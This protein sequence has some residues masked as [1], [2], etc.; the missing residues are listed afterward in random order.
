MIKTKL[1]TSVYKKPEDLRMA[2]VVVSKRINTRIFGDKGNP[3]PGTV[4]DDVVTLP[5]RYDFFVVSQCVRQGTVSPT[6]Y[7]VLYDNMG[8][9]PDRMQ[10]MAYK[11]CHMY[12]NWSGTVRVPAPCQYAHK[13]AF[14]T[15]QS[16][17]RPA[18]RTLEN[19]L[20]Y[21]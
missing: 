10:I 5:E 4:V 11:L 9:P 19:V 17:H 16:L 15:A 6:S 3:P 1:T 12:Y 14:L 8:L 2:F 21:L 18:N 7:N 20:Y 13:L